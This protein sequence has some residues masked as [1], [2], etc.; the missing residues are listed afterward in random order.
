MRLGFWDIKNRVKHQKQNQPAH[1]QMPLV[2][3][4]VFNL[5]FGHAHPLIKNKKNVNYKNYDD[6]D[7]VLGCKL[8]P[9]SAQG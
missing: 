9:V 1:K 5:V 7:D 8:V 3:L 6:N 4:L 2:L